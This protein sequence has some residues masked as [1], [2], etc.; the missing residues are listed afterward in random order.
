M[1]RGIPAP[2]VGRSIFEITIPLERTVD[3]GQTQY[4]KR[5]VAV[6]LE[7][8]V[9]GPRLTATVMPGALD[10]ELT[11]ANGTIEIEQTLVLRTSDG[12]YV[13]LRNAGTGPNADDVRVVLDFEAP[14]AS[15]H[16]KLN[17]GS[18]VARRELNASAKTLRLRVYDVS[19]VEVGTKNAIAIAK[20]TG[21][22]AQPWDY[23]TKSASERQGEILMRENVTLAPAQSV[24]PSK[25]GNRNI[26][27]ITGGELSGRI[28]G[29]VL[30]GGAD[31]QN[32]SPPATIDAHYLWQ[33][34][35]GEIIIVRNGGSFGSL[36]PSFETRVDGPFGYP[37]RGALSE[38]ES[39]RGTRWRGAH[40]LRERGVSGARQ[41]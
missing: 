9:A 5:R 19:S 2:E 34:D 36:V 31:F 1:P 35:N 15:E 38:L 3:V 26:I 29:K 24:G 40:V 13:Y 21:A 33:A 7:G 14:N 17:S 22:P 23:R 11:L 37:Q 28:T 20:P 6:G 12:S 10:F 4:G 18:Y 41:R 8:S 32:L 39:R 16:S 25:R 27:P 30:M